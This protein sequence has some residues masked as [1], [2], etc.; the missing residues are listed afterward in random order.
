MEESGENENKTIRELIADEG[1][2]LIR[3]IIESRKLYDYHPKEFFSGYARSRQK[4]WFE[5]IG[6]LKLPDILVKVESVDERRKIV[7]WFDD[8]KFYYL[9]EFKRLGQGID[10]YSTVEQQMLIFYFLKRANIFDTDNISESKKKQSIIFSRLLNRGED[11]FY[12]HYKKVES[13]KHERK[14]FTKEN[15]LTI[16]PLF[17]ACEMDEVL[18]L[19]DKELAKK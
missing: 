13:T 8:Y 4:D 12:D 14:Y 1:N 5:Q 15:L 18:K 9:H 16:R 3:N 6:I 7:K 2:E 11:S 19:I 17:E 10:S